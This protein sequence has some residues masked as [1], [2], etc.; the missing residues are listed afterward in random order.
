MSERTSSSDPVH[1]SSL[2]NKTLVDSLPDIIKAADKFK[3][4]I[5]EIR[6]YTGAVSSDITSGSMASRTAEEFYVTLVNGLKCICQTI[7]STLERR[8]F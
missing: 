2:R 7:S 8:I 3:C 4:R 6:T 1:A 5:T